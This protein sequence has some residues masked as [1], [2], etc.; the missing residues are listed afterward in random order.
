M[1][2][3]ELGSEAIRLAELKSYDVLDTPCEPAFDEIVAEA[4]EATDA[5]IAV[6]SLIDSERQWFKA[7]FGIDTPE[8]PRCMS[9]CDHTIRQREVMTVTDATKDARFATNPLVTGNPHI[10][11]YA[12]APL[13]TPAG[14]R[15][16]VL[17]VID[18]RARS[19]LAP[20]QV[21]RLSALAART[22]R[23]LEYRKKRALL[24]ACD[25]W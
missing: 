21:E 9:F 24:P 13:E 17:C 1:G 25:D 14:V 19:P 8:T 11:F 20:K 15:I 16:G 10:R 6:I 7:R 5:P 18:R 3:D 4:A 22:M 12:G 2:C 23:E